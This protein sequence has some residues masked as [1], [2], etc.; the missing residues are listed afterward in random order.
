MVL[1]LDVK[2]IKAQW[3]EGGGG[4]PSLAAVLG[5]GGLGQRSWVPRLFLSYTTTVLL[6]GRGMA[7]TMKV[8][9]RWGVVGSAY[10]RGKS[11]PG[12]IEGVIEG[13]G[14]SR[15]SVGSVGQRGRPK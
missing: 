11:G 14:L 12:F 4:E 8:P 9:C 6:E 15:V 10:G 2:N 3:K 7:N 13:S 1:A 5:G